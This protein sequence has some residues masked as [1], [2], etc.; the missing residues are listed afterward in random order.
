MKTKTCHG[1][2]MLT[3]RSIWSTLRTSAWQLLPRHPPGHPQAMFS[4]KP[5]SIYVVAQTPFQRMIFLQHSTG[6]ISWVTTSLANHVIRVLAALATWLQ[7]WPCLNQ[8]SSSSMAKKRAFHPSFLSS[9]TSSLRAA[10]VVGVTCQVCSCNPTTPSMRVKHATK[11]RPATIS[12]KTSRTQHLPPKCKRY[13]TS[14]EDM[15]RHVRRISW[16]KLEL[17]VLSYT[18][19]MLAM[20]SWLIAQAS[21]LSNHPMELPK[22]R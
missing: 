8:E 21:L 12:V 1:E 17:E 14:E 2:Q 5:K 18:I 7:Q 20:N 19:S 11:G 22:K 3:H 16:E 6:L 9:A 13:T 15:V 4:P 10:M